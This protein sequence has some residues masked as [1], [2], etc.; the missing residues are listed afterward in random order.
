MEDAFLREYLPLLPEQLLGLILQYLDSDHILL[1]LKVPS[2]RQLI[3]NEIYAREIHFVL[4][5]TRRPHPCKVRSD[6]LDI[7]TFADIDDFLSE[8]PDINPLTVAV[9]THGDFS[10]LQTLFDKYSSR[11]KNSVNNVDILIESCD[12]NPSDMDYVL[13]IPHLRRLHV[14]GLSSDLMAQNLYKCVALDQLVILGHKISSWSDVL[15][16]S[17]VTLLDISWN[18]H[19]QIGSMVFPENLRDLFLN[20]SGIDDTLLE[21]L[22]FPSS[23][24]T[25]QFT[26][27]DLKHFNAS[28][29]P[30]HLE[31]L[32]VSS[33]T[34][35]EITGQW[36]P[37][38]KTILLHG[39]NLHDSSFDAMDSWPQNLQT[40]RLDANRLFN[41][42]S[43]KELPSDLH[44][45]D[46]SQNLFTKFEFETPSKYPFFA[47][48][49]NLRTLFLT[50]NDRFQYSDNGIRIQFPATLTKL[51]ID[52]CNINSLHHFQFPSSLK[53]LSVSGNRLK[54]IS[55]YNGDGTNWTQLKSLSSLEFVFNQIED[56]RGWMPPKN[57]Q[58]LNLSE[59]N[60][61]MLTSVDTPIFQEHDLHL[62][63][64]ILDENSI[65]RI[66]D[67][68]FPLKLRTL[69]LENNLITGLL[70]LAPFAG[71][72]EV[73]LRGNTI[74]G[75]NCSAVSL[76][77]LTKLDL[78]QNEILRTSKDKEKVDAFFEKLET[79]LQRKVVRRKYNLNSVHT[80]K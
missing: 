6:V 11:F 76:S 10:S 4:S 53:S 13:S 19:T 3:I 24:R 17:S 66:G 23:L 20:M 1:L 21:K 56:L 54:D 78:T 79:G 25:I 67:V 61:K 40:L 42:G 75:I 37:Y 36:P 43:L 5:P 2:L 38:L 48:P 51:N 55:S 64:L 52:G 35:T 60:L 46:L 28:S 32:D 47:F 7:T 27:N 65:S 9:I 41:L 73:L 39:N 22:S 63:T 59:N 45:L 77:K 8:N 29:L 18:P 12:L 49:R 15:F 57:L 44:Y 62:F 71:I 69:S 80:F 68:K 14:G 70:E 74:T 30:K 16:P 26:H 34:I 31:T 50:G 33:N 58:L 72:R